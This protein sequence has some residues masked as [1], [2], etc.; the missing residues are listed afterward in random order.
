MA[1]LASGALFLFFG[2]QAMILSM[3]SMI[4]KVFISFPGLKGMD[5]GMLAA[6]RDAIEA[7]LYIVLPLMGVL[8]F[9]A[10]LANLA[11]TGFIFSVEPL[12]PKASKINPI[13]GAKRILSKRS[14][15]ELGKAIAKLLIVGWAAFSVL[16]A[17]FGAFLDLL[18]QE[19]VQ[20]FRY[21]GEASFRVI[22]R[23]CY[24]IAVLAILDYLY[25]KWEFEQSLKMTKQEVKEEFKQTEGDPLVKARIRSIQRQMARRRMMEEVKRAD[26]V[27]TNPTHL[28]IALS[29][30]ASGMKAPRVVAKGADKLALKIRERAQEHGVPLFEHKILAQNLYKSVDIGQ[31]IPSQFYRAVAEILAYV[32]SLKRRDQSY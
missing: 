3:G 6:G 15:V 23:S 22:T 1:V 10:V 5:G 9:I 26:V 25:Q 2:G 27:I 31:E 28:S 18:Y 12:A 13:E 14:M 7:C 19:D 11:Q 17:E 32:Y 4:R 30:E 8:V 21:M 29:Y 20:I 16:K 24:V